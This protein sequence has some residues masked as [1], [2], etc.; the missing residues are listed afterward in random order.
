MQPQTVG[1]ILDSIGKHWRVADNVEVTLEANP[2]SVEATRFSRLSRSPA[3]TASRS[4][5]RRS[6]TPR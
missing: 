6:M 5:C 1:S 4:A 3:S 2:T